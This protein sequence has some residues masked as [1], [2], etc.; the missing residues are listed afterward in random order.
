MSLVCRDNRVENKRLLWSLNRSINEGAWDVVEIC[1]D[2]YRLRPE[3]TELLLGFG[4]LDIGMPYLLTKV[5]FTFYFCFGL[6]V[7]FTY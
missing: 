6:Q 4:I 7:N 5:K 1:T 3:S 2:D